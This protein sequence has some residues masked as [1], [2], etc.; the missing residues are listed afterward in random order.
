MIETPLLLVLDGSALK[1]NKILIIFSFEFSTAKLK[2]VRPLMSLKLIL[3]NFFAK[4]RVINKK[5]RFTAHIS[6]V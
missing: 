3:E 2:A 6:P 1:H 5:L 4:N